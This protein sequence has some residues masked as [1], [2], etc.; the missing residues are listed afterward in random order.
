MDV[1]DK[2]KKLRYDLIPPELIEGLAEIYTRG[3]EVHGDR[4]W[5]EHPY[6]FS[7]R[8]ASAERHGW[9]W[10]KGNDL[11]PDGTGLNQALQAMFNWGL[12]YVYQKRGIG[13]DDRRPIL[14]TAR[15]V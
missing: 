12:L 15:R 3:A 14:G 5:E 8:F 7:E 2:S 11:D 6:K 10:Y 9:D 1:R 4:D 13:T